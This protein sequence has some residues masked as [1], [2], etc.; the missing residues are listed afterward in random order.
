[1][2]IYSTWNIMILNIEYDDIFNMV[3]VTFVLECNAVFKIE[4]DVIF[5]ME[6]DDI[7]NKESNY[8]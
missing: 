6:Y 3:Y 2:K 8:I 1:M 7:L 5:V 4:Y